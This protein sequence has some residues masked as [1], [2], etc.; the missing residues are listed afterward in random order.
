MCFL[1]QKIYS[2]GYFLNLRTIIRK[3]FHKK[4]NAVYIHTI[5]IVCIPYKCPPKKHHFKRVC[6]WYL[7]KM[8]AQNMLCTYNVK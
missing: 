7:Y 3:A 8:V 2:R 5:L 1:F 4:V 6:P